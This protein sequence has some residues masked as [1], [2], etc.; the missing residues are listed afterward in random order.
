MLLTQLLVCLFV[1]VG[2]EG[3]SAE[4]YVAT[5]YGVDETF[6]IHHGLTSANSGY[7]TYQRFISGCEARFGTQPC[8]QTERQRMA[9]NLEQGSRQRNYTELGFGRVKA[10]EAA[11]GPARRFWEAHRD[12]ASPETWPPGN[13]YVNSWVAPTQMVSF[14]D[15]RFQPL[16]LQ[17]KQAIWDGV[18]PVLEAWTGQTLKPTSL[19]GIRVYGPGAIL[20][21]HLDRLPLVTSAI[22]QIDQDLDDPW[23][24]EVV[25]HDG[26]A[27]NVTLQPGDMAL[28]ESHTIIHGRPHPLKGRFFA[29]VFVHFIPADHD[30]RNDD[31]VD[32]DWQQ[33]A[34]QGKGLHKH[35]PEPPP[36]AVA[37]DRATRAAEETK[38]KRGSRP[39]PAP[40]SHKEGGGKKKQE[41][42]ALRPA[43]P[44]R[45][46][47]ESGRQHGSHPAA[48]R[49]CKR[50]RRCRP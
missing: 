22:L 9:M 32:F 25:G 47:R 21:P 46:A 28:Y 6:P 1:V 12:E 27:Y 49:V 14:E 29:N 2:A 16:G 38:E 43:V 50:R 4:G 34:S 11:Y 19:Y 35:F 40:A 37:M 17:T 48:L 31:G 36:T 15:R 30:G 39:V 5:G 7:E 18:K 26:N 42:G 45:R 33:E 13:T 44:R 23:P 41:R 10:P 24:V 20:N 3:G 8:R